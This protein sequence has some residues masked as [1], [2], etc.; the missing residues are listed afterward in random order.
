MTIRLSGE[1]TSESGLAGELGGELKLWNRWR[2]AES[3]TSTLME[4]SGLTAMNLLQGDHTANLI[5]KG[6]TAAAVF[7]SH[8]SGIPCTTLTKGRACDSWSFRIIDV[9]GVNAS[10]E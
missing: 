7:E 4:Y 2:V 3:S 8:D 10:A 1:K 5:P 6:Q 9:F